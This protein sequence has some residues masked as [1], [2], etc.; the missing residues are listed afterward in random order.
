MFCEDYPC[1]GHTDGLGCDWVSPNEAQ[2]CMECADARVDR[3]YHTTWPNDCPTVNRRR[4]AEELAAAKDS[5]AITDTGK[6]CD[7]GEAAGYRYKKWFMCADCVEAEM[8]DEVYASRVS[9][10]PEYDY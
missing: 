9:Y 7:C 6:V 10:E 5:Y 3:P 4:E 1:C 8:L 2:L